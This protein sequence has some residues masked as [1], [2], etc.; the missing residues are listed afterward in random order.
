MSDLFDMPDFD[1]ASVSQIPA[2]LQLVNMGYT[3]LSREKVRQLRE[4][5]GQYILRDVAFDA[6]RA[7]NS[8]KI[9]GKSI[10]D[11]VFD[12][13]QAVD[14]GMGV[15]RASEEIY[16]LLLAG[17]AVSELID[18][19]RVSP[20]MK[21]IDWKVPANNTFHVCAEFELSENHERRPDIVLFVNG[22]PFAVIE[23][24]RESVQVAEA[25]TQMIRNQGR[26]ETPRFFLF[27]QLLIASNVR[28][29][30]YGTM[31]TPAKF[32]TH[33]KEKD[34]DPAVFEAEVSAVINKSVD[35]SI[36]SQITADLCRGDIDVA[37]TSPRAATE[38]D[39]GLYSLLMP[40]RMLDLVRNFVLYDGGIKKVARYQQYFAIRKTIDRL[41]TFDEHGRRRGG[42]IWHTQGSGKSLTMVMLV[43]CLIDDPDI[44]LPRVLVVTDRKDLDKQIADTF[45]ACSI[46]KDVKK[47]TSSRELMQLLREKDQRVI[48]ALIHKFEAAKTAR[49]FVDDDPNVFVLIDEAH[50]SQAGKANTELNLVLPRACQ[51]AFTGT[52][53]MKKEKSSAVK[54]GGVI[55]AYTISEAEADGVV[56]PLIYQPRFA[57]LEVKRGLLDKFYDQLTQGLSEGQKKDFQQKFNSPQLLEET[58]QRIETIALDIM[59]HYQSFIDTGLKAQVVAPSKYAAVL[60]QK[61][62]ELCAGETGVARSEVIV[63]DTNDSE[64][65]DQ[66][67]EH[68]KVVAEFLADEKH[69][70]GTS[71]DTR[72]KRLVADFKDNP[73]GVRILIVVDKLLTGFDAP[74]NTFLYLAKQLK[75]H[76]LLQA[77]ARVNRLFDGD[78]GREAKVN[79]FVIDYSRNGKN[80]R[81]AM[82]LF[83]HYDPDDV[84][85]A[86]LNTDEKI[87]ELEKVYQELRGI[88]NGVRNPKDTEEYLRVLEGDLVTRERFYELV[89]EFIKQ[90][91][92]CCMLYDFTKKFDPEKLRRYQTDL[93][94]FLELK[95]TAKAVNAESVDF[96][97]YIDQIRRILDKYVSADYVQALAEPICLSESLE[98][99]A[100]IENTD[101]GLSDK[102]KAEA[103]AAHTERTIKENY[104]KDPE[105]YRRFSDKIARLIEELRTAKAEDA[106]ALLEDARE[107]QGHV[108][109]YEDN[110]IPAPLKKR[111]PLHTY[112]RN[113]RAALGDA[114][115]SEQQ[116]ATAT[117]AMVGIVESHKII[118]WH[119]NVEVE[120]RVRVELEDYLFDVVQEQFGA[121][122]AIEE[123][124]RIIS[125]VWELAVENR[126]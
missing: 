98:F 34:A 59:E 48:T 25:V 31:L 63:S 84:D 58:S 11:A 110:D 95:K 46:K 72:E 66:L 42:L 78:E 92:A 52:P 102:S 41:K 54:Y 21:F 68:K 93:K 122:M 115:I 125:M 49:D 116:L 57:E 55:D 69:R 119:K 18:G 8:P 5:Q 74:R 88:F 97:K 108:V 105:F 64:A 85:R 47:T 50:R 40:G 56:L 12:L 22:I 14:M 28:K 77:I 70:H 118:D 107:I 103:I 75:D 99:N 53:L 17:R 6:L 123:I 76:N 39:K 124:D 16:A 2:L 9:S 38:Q 45:A 37:R 80:L 67:P 65:D 96:S 101:R 121:A 51:I 19:R 29:L 94:K 36:V 81:D 61:A 86:L 120:R 114:G 13:E 62:F 44:V 3:Y 43:K 60:F 71:L 20:Q 90:F 24:K 126:E 4:S 82:Q 106:R 117:E 33:W 73:E 79:G 112:Y 26:N 10:R 109:D 113:L 111:K 15:F 7:I 100:Y 104:H 89:N 35:P 23:C 83:T 30:K 91:A 87:Q 32:Y 1:E 27:P